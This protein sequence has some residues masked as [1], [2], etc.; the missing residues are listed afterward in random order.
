MA[1]QEFVG[2]VAV[3]T[4]GSG[5]L[6]GHLAKGL[7]ARGAKVVV[8]G[9]NEA[10][11]AAVVD[12]IRGAGGEAMAGPADCADPRALERL[13]DA[14][15]ERYGPVDLLA[16]FAG[17]ASTSKFSLEMGDEEWRYAIGINLDA[18]FYAIR[19]F[20]PDMVAKRSGAILTMSSLA[21]RQASMAAIGYA[22]SKGAIISM[23]RHL[24][25]ELGPSQVRVNC[26]APGSVATP[27]W[28]ASLAP[29]VQKR[30]EGLSPLGRLGTEADITEASLFLLSPRAG[31]V[32]GIVFDVAGGR[33]MV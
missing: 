1:D 25:Q 2:Q 17:G 6:G 32:T 24:A 28:L 18:T 13:R 11:I 27:H 12:A 7:A 4:G 5:G 22:A 29:D 14:V 15:H 16:A 9:R 10:A 3:V 33:V 20:A 26:I 19:T 31:W 8:N 23:S 21:A 30:L